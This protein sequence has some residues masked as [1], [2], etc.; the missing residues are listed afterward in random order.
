M[1]LR[2]STL[3]LLLAFAHASTAQ[4]VISLAVN[5]S[6][7]PKDSLNDASITL[8][9]LPD[10]LLIGSQLY[11]PGGNRFTLN[12][13]TK[14]LLRVSSVNFLPVERMIA[15]TD[16]PLSLSIPVK[17]KTTDLQDVTVVSR[18]PVIK[19]EDDKSVVDA[20]ALS[21]SSTNAYEVLEKTPGTIV[22]QDGNVYLSSLTPA[23]VYING[24]E[25]KLSSEDL[26]SLLKSLPASSVSKIEILRNP[27]AKFDA[28]SSGGIINIVLKKGVKIGSNGSVNIAYFQGVYSTQTAGFNINKSSGR[29]NSYLSY[30][31]TR[32]N[33]YE[34]LSSTR[35]IRTDSSLLSQNAYTSYPGL[36]N[37]IGGGFDMAFTKKFNINYDL[38]INQNNG[39]S[40]ALN[41]I[42][43]HK[44][45]AQTTTGMNSSDIDNRNNA[46]Y[47]GNELSSKYKIDT[48]GSEWTVELEYNYYR[49]RNNQDYANY[50]YLPANPTVSGN[51]STSGRKNIFV[52]QTDLVLKLPRIVN[53]ETG[54][55]LTNSNSRN[56]AAYTIDPGTGI[57]QTDAYQTNTFRYRETITAAYLQVSR[58]FLGFTLKP[59]LRLETTDINGRQLVPRDTNLSINRTDLFP[60]VYL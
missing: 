2:I 8:Y 29:L 60:Y 36:G 49:N 47:I 26:A 5:L 12:T 51:G 7:S 58:T 56:S 40:F 20:T 3:L 43:I 9:K 16:K 44:L 17:R 57:P 33:N 32:R 27:S 11:K 30:Q 46:L 28:A 14:Y 52:F 1:K 24:R 22:D 48:L 39:K 42:S 53:I 34:E 21:N 45:P 15:T 35:F 50:Y 4:S 19:Q 55:K 41:E 13:Y 54:F 25:M 10:T 37:Y 38:R 18:K 31:F 6:S 59:G 23:T